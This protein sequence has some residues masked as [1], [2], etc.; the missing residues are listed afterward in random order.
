V[1]YTSS[2]RRLWRLQTS[3]GAVTLAERLDGTLLVASTS[4]L[5]ALTPNGTRLWQR[6]FVPST[7]TIV[8][9]SGLPA[10]AVDA[11]GRTYIG[12]GDGL[13]RAIG[14]D[15]TLLWT[16]GAPNSRGAPSIA[17]GPT[18]QLVIASDALRVYR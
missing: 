2:G 13:V 1:A 15:G 16:L 12:S 17:L 6:S 10:L 3:D 14:P 7:G 4:G 5:T 8:R 9:F 11:A 18:G